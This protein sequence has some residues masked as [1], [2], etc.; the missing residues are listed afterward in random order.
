MSF[1][2][3]LT[4]KVYSEDGTYLGVLDD[5]ISDLT[6]TRQINGGDNEFTIALARKYDDFDENNTIKFNNRI[7]VFL[8]DSYNVAG[9]KLVAYGYIISYAPF[10]KGKE[11]GVEVTCLSAVSKLS[12]DFYRT[13]SSADA[14]E[15]GVELTSKRADEM[16]EA[17]ITHYRTIESNSMLSNDF[18]NA[19]ATTDNVGTPTTFTHR[20]FNMKHLDAMRESAKFLPKN[21][22]GGY[23]FY[24]RID[25]DGKLWVKNIS[26][27]AD[28]SFIIGKHI[29]EIT[30]NKT[31]EDL[32]N[33]I[34][35]WNEKGTVDP[36][37][38]KLVDDDTTSQTSYDIVSSYITDS[39]ITNTTAA[40]LLATAKLYD[41]KDPKIQIKLTLTG[42]YDLAS[43]KP[44]QTCTILNAK[45]NPYVLGNDKVLL[46]ESV[47][48]SPDSAI[49]ELSNGNV[50]FED[51]VEE[52]RQRLDKE[53]T[54][55]GY[56]SQQL[57]AA[58][59]APVNRSWVT[60]ITFTAKTGADAYRNVT[61][62]TGVV[63]IPSG[64]G[65]SA[66]VRQVATGESGNLSAA[67]PYMIYL[68]ELNKPTV[69]ASETGAAGVINAG[70]EYLTDLSKSWTIDQWAGYVVI[71]NG[72]RQIIK[73]NTATT[74]VVEE[75]FLADFT[76]AFSIAKLAFS[77]TST[78]SV[79]VSHSSVIFS[80]VQASTNTDSE[81]TITPAGNGASVNVDGGTQIAVLSVPDSRIRDLTVDKLTTGT[82]S[83]KQIT[84][85]VTGGSGDV[86]IAAGKTDFDN[87]QTG[88][89]LGIDD[90]DSDKPKFYIGNTTRYLN[91]TGTSLNIA[92][93]ISAGTIDIGGSDATSFHVD[94]DG[95]MWLGAA[96]YNITTNPFAVSN[97][98]VIRAVSG[99]IGGNVLGSD[100]ISSTTFVSGPLGNGWKINND[101]S[102]EFQKITVRGE[103]RTAVFQKDNI[104]AVNGLM[105]ITKADI[106]DTAMTALDASTLTV[107]G[108]TAFV[109]NE[110][111]RLKDGSDDEW[112]LVTDASGAPTYVVTRD[113]A[114][115]Y[116]ADSNPAWPEGTAVVSMGVGTGTKTGFIMLDSSSA[117]SPYIDVYGRNSNTYTDY[118]LNVRVGWLKGITDAAVGLSSTDVWGLY[119][120]SVYLTG[121][122]NAT[123]GYF[124]NATNGL[125][126]D[127]T[128]L[129]LTGTGYFRTASSGSRIVVQND[130]TYGH[131]ISG[132]DS[133]GLKFNISPA[134][135][136]MWSI[137]SSSGN[138]V[139]HIGQ[140][141]G[142]GTTLQIIESGT[143]T[144]HLFEA[145]ITSANSAERANKA[146][147]YFNNAAVK[148]DGL[149]L[150]NTH[151][152]YVGNLIH[153]STTTAKNAN[154]FYMPSSGW[155]AVKNC[156]ITTEGYL[157]FPAYHHRSEF[158]ETSAALAS[159]VIANAYWV[160]GGTSGTQE[161]RGG[162]G[163]GLFANDEWT[164]AHLS[165]TST[166]SRSST[167]TF[168]KN[169]QT[170][171]QSMLECYIN[172][173]SIT[174]T[175][176]EWG[177]KYDSTH[178]ALFRFDTDVDAGNIYF[179]WRN[180]GSET[181][182]D[183]GVNLTATVFASYRIYIY[184][185]AAYAFINDDAVTIGTPDIP[186]YCA[187]YFYIDNKAASEEK[188]MQIDYVDIWHGRN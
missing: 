124:G 1:S 35:F 81:V 19:D 126:V 47:E 65:S 59:L 6:I 68:D 79:A 69:A 95:N 84:L 57:T 5:V 20:F 175:K 50:K 152:S 54:W 188:T 150:R 143:G 146:G 135:D 104:S 181:V 161:I 108:S 70:G 142:S 139:I 88:F 120:N 132:F 173:S 156:R 170:T 2:R 87:T 111:V 43:I 63:Y 83:S 85:A 9:D 27:T 101:G 171:G 29:K 186:T 147:F 112:M 133:G 118:T 109:A 40:T 131:S 16:M 107:T 37:Y 73:S 99:T 163:G 22:T 100:Y 49:L 137:T 151:A 62:T 11:E 12:N 169:T 179:V 184:S 64:S 117:N 180:G 48:Y 123:S 90:S 71:V 38:I 80:N 174:N 187:P 183:T 182:T 162:D 134:F 25:T 75:Y 91:W 116:G 51:I 67:T 56:I 39:K 96:T 42:D 60:D 55:F 30:G 114:G 98:G 36:D 7:K 76:G 94:A 149:Y 166:A 86:Y 127:S 17:I 119:S 41:S 164:Y 155:S 115:A 45:N 113:L 24:W 72:E 128:G 23:W 125:T 74:L 103:I 168:R 10:L 32:V 4:Y 167:L 110:V 77:V 97:A 185:N 121:R 102:A 148:G 34:Y 14:S 13:G 129:T 178:Y 158:D 159:T 31:I 8:K 172:V 177:W 160:G 130:T 18:S 15:L 66:S 46:I 44:G 26:Q 165:T 53:M 33:R 61:W 144:E 58:Q 52:E 92:G 145:Q 105:L 176:M 106:L 157:D 89:I 136:P 138:D 122:L 3:K 82:I 153:L 93:S 78:Q 140:S 21:K 28:H 154:A 141:S